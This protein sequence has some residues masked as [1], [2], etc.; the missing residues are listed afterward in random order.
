MEESN[1]YARYK[2]TPFD[3]TR[4]AISLVVCLIGTFSTMNMQY[5]DYGIGTISIYVVFDS[6]FAKRDFL[7]H[8]MIVIVVFLI[9][10]LNDI[11]SGLILHLK[12]QWLKTEYSTILYNGGPLIMDALYYTDAKHLIPAVKTASQVGF[13]VLFVQCRIYNYSANVIL[14][15]ALYDYSN[16]NHII[17]Y[18]QLI[19]ICW[20]FYGLNLYWLQL[21][22][23]RLLPLRLLPLRKSIKHL[24]TESD[25]Q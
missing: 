8:H 3:K 21:I 16:Y 18:I 6:F 9:V 14:L 7:I 13:A 25:S 24:K 20:I 23:L 1:I 11:D 17:S 19:G 12:H 22:L 4:Y 2:L 15:E 5:V 10:F